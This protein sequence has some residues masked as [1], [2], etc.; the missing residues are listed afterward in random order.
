MSANTTTA[1]H[2]HTSDAAHPRGLDFV[3]QK[4][5]D[6]ASGLFA[7]GDRQMATTTTSADLRQHMDKAGS[8]AN[9]PKLPAV[10][11]AKANESRK[12]VGDKLQDAASEVKPESQKSIAEKLQDAVSNT[13]L[14]TKDVISHTQHGADE[15]VNDVREVAADKLEDASKVVRPDSRTSHT[16]HAKERAL[17]AWA[18]AEQTT[19]NMHPQAGEHLERAQVKDEHVK[20]VGE[21]LQDAVFNTW[22]YTKG[23]LTTRPHAAETAG[24]DA[25]TSNAVESTKQGAHNI[26]QAVRDG[27]HNT[28]RATNEA[29]HNT[30]QVT[31]DM[32]QDLA[33]AT[34]RG[35]DNAAHGTKVAVHNTAQVAGDMAHDTKEGAHTAAHA[36]REGVHHWADATKEAVHNTAQVAGDMAHDTKEATR[37]GVHHWADAT[38]KAVHNTARVSSDMASDLAEATKEGA[39]SAAHATKEAAHN[40]AQVAGDMAHDT[41]EATR[42]GVHHWAAATQVAVHNTARVSSDM[43]SDLAEAT[44]EGA[45][46]AAHATKEGAR[47][48]GHATQVRAEEGRKQARESIDAAAEKIGQVAADARETLDHTAVV[49]KRAVEPA[50]T[51]YPEYHKGS[52]SSRTII[53]DAAEKLHEATHSIA[54]NVSEIAANLQHGVHEKVIHS[55]SARETAGGLLDPAAKKHS[56]LN[57]EKADQSFAS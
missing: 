45:H 25:R 11:Q 35:A 29:A 43:A 26:A 31:T 46:S 37:E 3:I 18:T 48:V 38:Q 10:A 36:T 21:K 9:E 40:T 44:K 33:H 19:E 27:A 32:T 12:Y 54:V 5:V 50:G 34:K 16:E 49:V 7:A 17:S 41:K 2:G 13:W 52:G 51:A 8:R 57:T 55:S 23:V 30:A 15:A 53:M 20:T 42:E 22:E 4:T 1:P 39:H 56:D 14:S 28:A 6:T 24:Q 47:E